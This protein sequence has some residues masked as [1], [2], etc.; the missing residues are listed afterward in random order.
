MERKDFAESLQAPADGFSARDVFVEN[1]QRSGY[2]Y[3]DVIFLPGYIDF[4]VSE[5]DMTSKLTKNVTLRTPA[6][7]SP[8]DTVTEANMAIAMA[9][10]GGIGIIHYNCSVEHQV[11]EVSCC[12]Q[13]LGGVILSEGLL[14]LLL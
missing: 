13:A 10:Q 2:T 4:G 14:F 3:D 6:I 9:L 7:S 1:K 5:I 12:S 11:N 8:M